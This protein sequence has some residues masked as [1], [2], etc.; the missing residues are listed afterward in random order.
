MTTYHGMPRGPYPL[1]WCVLPPPLPVGLPASE[2]D[3]PEMTRESSSLLLLLLPYS[4]C[5]IRA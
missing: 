5:S 4:C 1:V 2:R 3:L